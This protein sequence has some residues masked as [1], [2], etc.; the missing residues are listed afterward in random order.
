M[1]KEGREVHSHV[2][3]VLMPCH[4]TPPALCCWLAEVRNFCPKTRATLL[5]LCLHAASADVCGI[6]EL[7]HACMVSVF[8]FLPLLCKLAV[9]YYR[10]CR[11]VFDELPFA[12]QQGSK[13]QMG[14]GMYAPLCARTLG[15]STQIPVAGGG[16]GNK[17]SIL[18]DQGERR[19]ANG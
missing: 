3:A 5:C 9:G 8:R 4:K 14:R 18:I 17:R 15:S 11:C 16:A 7:F 12:H 1:S 19:T 10:T 6:V 13:E 2:L